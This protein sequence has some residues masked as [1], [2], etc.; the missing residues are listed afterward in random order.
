MA[1]SNIYNPAVQYS[2]GGGPFG[3]PMQPVPMPQP[4]Q[5][6]ANQIPGLTNLNQQASGVI[7]NQLAGQL[8]PDT[9]TAIRNAAATQSAASGM[10]GTSAIAGTLGGN[11]TLRDI[12]L[13]SAQTQQQGI[14]N[15]NSFVPTVAS[16]QTVNP[17]LQAEINT[18]NAVSASA[19]NPAAAQTYAQQL[20]QSYIS[21]LNKPQP[22]EAGKLGLSNNGTYFTP[23]GQRGYFPMPTGV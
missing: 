7:G 17:S 11:N 5:D 1:T 21:Q 12:G 13:T 18:Q 23:A 8:N 20:F 10:P 9:V 2:Y 6:V 19:P 14:A 4:A 16:T 22:T 3:N 15:Y